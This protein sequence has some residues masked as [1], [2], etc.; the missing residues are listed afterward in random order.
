M[1]TAIGKI[2]VWIFLR[3][4]LWGEADLA[5]AKLLFLGGLAFVRGEII[6]FVLKSRTQHPVFALLHGLCPG[7]PLNRG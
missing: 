5:L 6:N 4:A 3:M 2:V 7:F 1:M